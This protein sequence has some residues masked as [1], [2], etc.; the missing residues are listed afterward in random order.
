MEI[1]QLKSHFV[2]WNRLHFVTWVGSFTHLY[3]HH[4]SAFL[5]PE[6]P[7]PSLTK[8]PPSTNP[9]F[10]SYLPLFNGSRNA[11]GGAG[12]E[13][14][15]VRVGTRRAEENGGGRGRIDGGGERVGAVC[16]GGT[17]EEHGAKL[18]SK[19]I[20]SDRNCRI[21]CSCVVEVISG[22]RNHNSLNKNGY[23]LAVINFYDHPS[24]SDASSSKETR[25]NLSNS[26]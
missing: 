25:Y 4:H 13:N 1:R 7:S 3:L 6:N 24:F 23:S 26:K 18:R 11:I 16:G 12:V 20:N 9:H 10:T 8:P 22:N 17:T 2:T 21:T 15:E 14:G 19:G 5:Q